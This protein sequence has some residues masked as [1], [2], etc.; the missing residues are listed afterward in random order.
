MTPGQASMGKVN[1]KSGDTNSILLTLVI[2]YFSNV[3][4]AWNTL[5]ARETLALG[6]ELLGGNGILADFLVAKVF[7]KIPHSNVLDF[8]NL[9]YR[10]EWT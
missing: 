9:F 6:R 7:T 10:G 8:F 5:K 1:M 2:T 4:Q 3:Y